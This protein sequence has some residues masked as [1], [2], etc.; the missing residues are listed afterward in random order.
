MTHEPPVRSRST[1]PTAGAA[2]NRPENDRPTGKRPAEQ[3]GADTTRPVAGRPAA[4]SPVAGR[5]A[6]GSPVAGAAA[7]GARRR[8]VRELRRGDRVEGLV[9]LVETSNFKQTRNQKYFIQMSLRDRTGAIRAIRWEA[10][11]KLYNSFSVDDF[12]RVDGRVEEFQQNPQLIV[13]RVERV[14]SRHVD[15][16]DFLPTSA[17]DIDEMEAE[18]RSAIATV[19]CPP[20]RALLERFVAEPEVLRGLRNCP[21]GKAL[22]H[23]YIGGLLEHILSLIGLARRLAE[24]YPRLSR[25]LLIASC[26]L[27]DIGKLEELSYTR[28]FSYTDAGQLIGHVGLGLMMVDREARLVPDFPPGLLLELEHIIA[29]HHGLLEYGALKQPMTP[30]A[31]AF[32]YLDNLDSKMATLASAEDELAA[33]GAGAAGDGSA[34]ADGS[35]RGTG[36]RW[37][38]YKP[39]LGRKL[40]FPG[41]PA[42]DPKR[43]A[44]D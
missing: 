7:A 35:E 24:Q 16:D 36:G 30:E 13:D 14:E 39:H 10:D 33:F 5:P 21:A 19:E 8:W 31:V 32:H 23:A 22:H 26:L 12:V 37:S 42:E 20:L 27:H 34:G 9:L 38:D 41:R 43:L 15:F 6:A 4:G 25:D 18:L 3:R 17:R 11:E 44:G 2:T 40:Y 29:S 28:N 1:P